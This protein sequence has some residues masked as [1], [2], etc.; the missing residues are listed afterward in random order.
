MKITAKA[1]RR[2]VDVRKHVGMLTL[3][4]D[5]DADALALSRLRTFLLSSGTSARDAIN[6]ALDGTKE[7]E[8]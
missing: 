7:R 3:N 5:D 8:S 4:A 1:P 6:A 2:N